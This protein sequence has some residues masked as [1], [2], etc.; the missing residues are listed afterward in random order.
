MRHRGVLLDTEAH[1]E[2]MKSYA[3]RRLEAAGAYRAACLD[4]G[5]PELAAQPAGE[6]GREARP[7]RGD[8]VER[9]AALLAAHRE[10][11]RAL[12]GAR[13][14]QTGGALSADPGA[15][16]LVPPRQD[17]F[18][19]RPAA[20]GAG[21]AGDR[22]PACGLQRR[23]RGRRTRLVL[24]PQHAAS[25]ARQGLPGAVQGGGR[26]RLR[27]R[28]LLLAWSSGPPRTSPATAA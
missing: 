23:R 12:D 17:A 15:G 6:A 9:R 25:A 10:I 13:R 7:A 14:A 8:P 11:G 28:R 18:R 19:L 1:A 21:V 4:M 2:L 27:R 26:L 22:A 3:A 20:G 16:R 5:R 24:F